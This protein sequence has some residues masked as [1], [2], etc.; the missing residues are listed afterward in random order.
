MVYTFSPIKENTRTFEDVLT[1]TSFVELLVSIGKFK[2][3]THM[4]Y[5]YGDVVRDI[6][7]PWSELPN[8]GLTTSSF[9]EYVNTQEVGVHINVIDVWLGG[10]VSKET[11]I[12]HVNSTHWIVDEDIQTQSMLT[13]VFV[14]RNLITQRSFTIRTYSAFNIDV[15]INIHN[16]KWNLTEGIRTITSPP[17]L[18]RHP[19]GFYDRGLES[20]SMI[21][22]NL[23]DQIA[24]RVYHVLQPFGTASEALTIMT[25][26][27]CNGYH[28]L[29]FPDFVNKVFIEPTSPI[30]C[31]ICHDTDTNRCVSSCGDP[32]HV[33]HASCYC[34]WIER[35]NDARCILCKQEPY[36][37][38]T[39]TNPN[40]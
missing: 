36:L 29:D 21:I 20:E 38:K 12:K 1:A 13:H 19:Y 22:S 10:F 27:W 2:T 28:C 25:R 37:F 18:S 24:D 11:L 32:R 40:Q 6:I 16:L 14:L 26:L 3:E 8:A 5:V 31:S 39:M 9:F 34:K 17:Y 7:V 35:T 4:T 30:T 23:R 15:R 33:V